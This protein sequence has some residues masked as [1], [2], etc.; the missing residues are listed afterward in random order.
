MIISM[1]PADTSTATG[2]AEAEVRAVLAAYV[3]AHA[4]RDAEHPRVLR[5]RRRPLQSRARCSRCGND[6]RRRRGHPGVACHVDGPV[7]L[8][9]RDLEVAAEGAV[10]FAYALTKMTAKPFRSPEPFSFWLRSTFG[11]RLLDSR[12]RIVREHESTPLHG[13]V[14]PRRDRPRTLTRGSAEWRDAPAPRRGGGRLRERRRRQGPGTPPMPAI[15]SRGWAKRARTGLLLEKRCDTPRV[16]PNVGA[17]R[18]SGEPEHAHGRE[19]SHVRDRV[20][21]AARGCLSRAGNRSADQR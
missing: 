4:R 19:G 20:R 15:V 18:G 8:E 3:D 9:H 12:W 6:G 14:L 13:R 11:L 17:A 5:G 7:L 10:A 21:P 16:H 2:T 1:P